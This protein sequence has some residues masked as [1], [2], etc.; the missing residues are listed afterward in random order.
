MRQVA[1]LKAEK[2]TDTGK[3][4]ARKLRAGG[5][6]PAVVYGQG[7]DALLLSV[8]SLE[9]MN[10]F[11][12]RHWSVRSSCIRS[13]PSSSTSTSTRSRRVWRSR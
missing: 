1:N 12:S 5:R 10:L 11:R 13:V 9:T 6:S 3:G 4:V 7:E 8:D 2:R